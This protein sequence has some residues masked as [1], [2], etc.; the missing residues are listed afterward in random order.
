MIHEH[1]K[2]IHGCYQHIKAQ[3]EFTP[4]YQKRTFNV[5]ARSITFNHQFSEKVEC[6]SL[7]DNKWPALG[8]LSP[9]IYYPNSSTSSTGRRFD[10]PFRVS[11][12]IARPMATQCRQ[13]IGNNVSAW[14][15][16]E[17]LVAVLDHLPLEILPTRVLA[18]DA[19][20][21]RQVIDFL[22]RSDGLEARR[23]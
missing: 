6:D 11:L 4:I 17:L 1:S 22:I 2:W 5:P 16:A 13:I 3:V 20:G 14:H 21:A 23:L 19:K 7:L 15:E 18:A 12:G 10:N 9:S 8:N